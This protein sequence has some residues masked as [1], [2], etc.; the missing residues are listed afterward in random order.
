MLPF[1]FQA[2]AVSRRGGTRCCGGALPSAGAPWAP[3]GVAARRPG[4]CR[5]R[6]CAPGPERMARVQRLSFRP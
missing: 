6:P 5:A 4:Q 2:A 1:F 3:G